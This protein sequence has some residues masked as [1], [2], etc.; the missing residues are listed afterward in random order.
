MGSSRSHSGGRQVEDSDDALRPFRWRRSVRQADASA[1]VKSPRACSS[2]GLGA[3]QMGCDPLRSYRCY[4]NAR[5]AGCQICPIDVAGR[6]KRLDGAGV[7][8]KEHLWRALRESLAVPEPHRFSALKSQAEAVQHE[9]VVV[10]L[11]Q[12]A[13]VDERSCFPGRGSRSVSAVGVFMS[14][15]HGCKKLTLRFCIAVRS[16]VRTSPTIV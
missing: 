16:R 15:R 6:C 2:G 12:V 10:A 7:R 8:T 5:R 3:R 14:S 4:R 11:Y 9:L 13:K 1:E